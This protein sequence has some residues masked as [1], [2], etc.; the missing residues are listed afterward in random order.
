MTWLHRL[1]AL[2][3]SA[4]P[5]SAE[6]DPQAWV[7]QTLAETSAP[8]VAAGV[9]V[10]GQIS[11]A[12]GGLRSNRD[13]VPVTRDDLWHIGSITK[14]MTGTLIARLA[15]AGMIRWD[16]TVGAVLGE[17]IEGLHPGYADLTYAD[18]LTHRNGIRPNITIRQTR[19]M[20]GSVTTRDMMADRI[21]YAQLVLTKAPGERGKFTYSNAAY[22]VAGA[23]LQQSTGQTWEALMQ[24]HVFGPLGLTSAGFGPPGT[25][26]VIDQPR[27]HGL[28]L[29]RPI[30]PGPKADNIPALGPAGTVHISVADMLTYLRAHALRDQGF[31]KV[32][33]WARLHNVEEGADYAMGWAAIA[34]GWRGHEGSNTMWYATAVFVP[35]EDKAVFMAANYAGMSRIEAVMQE[36][37]K[38]LLED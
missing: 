16:D 13:D 24:D 5:V 12:A 25:V 38:A 33:S 28:F 9:V 1:L 3:L 4:T 31:L 34:P 6:F 27:G 20:L 21:A 17:A 7:D 37:A 10:D 29:R 15:E 14:S 35:G 32:E 23:M 11:I 30:P 26:E 36:G 8:G 18:L 22:V 2:T 19:A